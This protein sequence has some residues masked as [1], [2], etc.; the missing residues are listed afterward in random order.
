MADRQ[1]QQVREAVRA[2]RDGLK[3][4]LDQSDK[5]GETAFTARSRDIGITNPDIQK[6]ITKRQ[7]ALEA[8]TRQ[9]EKVLNKQLPQGLN[10]NIDYKGLG[11]GDV[12]EGRLP[13]VGARYEKPVELGGFKGTAG[14]S[15]RYDPESKGYEVGARVTGRFAKGGKVKKY[16]KGGGIRKPKLK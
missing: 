7:V 5:L 8:I 15:G 10:I 12:A 2:I 6:E 1:K 16:A 9:G 3:Y 11:F 13:A 14:I 4:Q